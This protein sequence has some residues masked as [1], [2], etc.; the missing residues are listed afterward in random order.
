MSTTANLWGEIAAQPEVRPPIVILKEQ[1]SKLSELTNML[2]VGEVEIERKYAEIKMTL[3]IIAPSLDNYEYEVLRAAHEVLMY[4]VNV[5]DIN[6]ATEAVP[7]E[8]I[9]C[10]NETEFI[11][12]LTQILTSETVH[13][14]IASLLAQTKS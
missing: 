1:A 11:T 9:K 12:V 2:L 5:Y 8:P 7:W 4:P 6:S 10:E 13:K 3:S 14:V